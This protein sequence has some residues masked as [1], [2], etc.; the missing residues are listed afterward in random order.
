M[1][2]GLAFGL[3]AVLFLMMCDIPPISESEGENPYKLYKEYRNSLYLLQKDITQVYLE[4]DKKNPQAVYEHMLQVIEKTAPLIGEANTASQNVHDHLQISLQDHLE[5]L[6][7]LGLSE[8]QKENLANLGYAEEDIAELLTWLLHY[9]DYYHHVSTGF[10]PEEMEWFYSG[11]LTDDEISGLQNILEEHYIQLYTAQ[12]MVKQHQT[13][14]LYIQ[15]SLSIAAS[16]ILS[17]SDNGKNKDNDND[18]EKMLMNA[19]KRLLEVI[20]NVS[21][22]QS[23]LE[24]VKALSKQVYKAAEQQVRKGED[25]YLVD[26]FVGLQVHCGALTALHGDERVGLA[27]I[28]RY[29]GV[30]A[31]CASSPE[32][33][34][35][36]SEHSSGQPIS[37]ED[38]IPMLTYM[39]Q[40]E[41][42][43]ETNN[44]GVAYLFVK[45]SDT[46]LW[47]SLSLLVGF[48]AT[49]FSQAEFSLHSMVEFL[50]VGVSVT[51]IG[52]GVAG[53]VFLL[54]VT[55]PSVG[56][57]WPPAVPGW[58][59]GDQVIIIVEGS[60]G[61]GHI[62]D[63]AESKDECI[64]SS[65]QAILD[66]KYMIQKIVKNATKLFFNP[67]NG[68][69]VYYFVDSAGKEWAV[70]V[71]EYENKYYELKTAYRADCAPFVCKDK[72]GIIHE[73]YQIIEKWLCE[74][75]QLI[76]L[77]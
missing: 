33:P 1:K 57:E 47:E 14:L 10:A 34:A 9:N 16:Q 31:E 48:V 45:A 67:N 13:E 69:Y 24:Q 3:V 51:A 23:S 71:E 26:F 52:I 49:Y 64:A 37:L 11:G 74:G 39:G 22:D 4:I 58:I 40:V 21:E 76:S 72:N 19:E 41:E 35:P 61:Q 6:L 18:S 75:F 2:K 42:F 12:Q 54:V 60:Y 70:F 50:T 17:E 15:V 43:D 68:Q 25:Q 73:Y 27:E 56:Y 77:W 62:P 30:V 55:A 5:I 59:E 46:S 8:E 38:T 7:I 44:I 29:K 28:Q 36:Q 20:G 32:R 63:R 66:D 53:A 65:H